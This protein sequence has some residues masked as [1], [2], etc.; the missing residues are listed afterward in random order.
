MVKP[1]FEVALEKG[2][3]GVGTCHA[4]CVI[5]NSLCPYYE[6]YS[7]IERKKKLGQWR[8]LVIQTIFRFDGDERVEGGEGAGG[9][10]S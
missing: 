6:V 3:R 1:L 9:V 7:E 10:Y 4:E 5:Y 8:W 2:D